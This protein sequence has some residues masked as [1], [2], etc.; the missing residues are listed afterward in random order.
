MGA[1][2]HDP[3]AN[4]SRECAHLLGGIDVAEH[5]RDVGERDD[6]CSFGQDR[7]ELIE[8]RPPVIVDVDD[9]DFRT[10]LPGGS[11][12][13]QQ[14]GRMLGDREHDFVAGLEI[15]RAPRARHKVDAFSRATHEDDLGRVRG[16]HEPGESLTRAGETI[17]RAAGKRVHP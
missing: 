12:P 6:P 13:R 16:V 2:N 10:G 15:R 11:G 3:R 14:I 9:S 7:F 5:I 1:V 4:F 8:P 17:G